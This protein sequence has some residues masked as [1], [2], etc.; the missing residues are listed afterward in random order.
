[1]IVSNK[2]HLCPLQSSTLDS[3]HR[4][5]LVAPDGEGRQ[6]SGQP[7]DASTPGKSQI[8]E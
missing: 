4:R 8:M 5:L 7:S 6:A 3:D 2:Y 1:M